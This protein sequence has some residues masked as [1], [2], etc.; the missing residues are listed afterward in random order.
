[1]FVSPRHLVLLP[2]AALLLVAVQACSLNPQPL[3]P[4]LQ[5]A[6]DAGGELVADATAGT[7]PDS[8]GPFG[9]GGADTGTSVDGAVPAVPP[10][11]AVAD[12][13]TDG[14]VEGAADGGSSDGSSE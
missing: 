4:G 7:T 2:G 1:M 8:G 6:N 11:G 3:P 10:D 9:G 5:G 13:A 12:A 14:E